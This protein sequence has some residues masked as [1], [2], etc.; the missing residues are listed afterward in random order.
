MR[1]ILSPSV[2]LYI[3]TVAAS[4]LTAATVWG[5]IDSNQMG[6]LTG[7]AAAVCGMAALN[8]PTKNEQDHAMGVVTP[9]DGDKTEETDAV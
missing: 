7:V 2:R 9:R 3:Y 1:L 5:Y 8:T 4:I 6:A